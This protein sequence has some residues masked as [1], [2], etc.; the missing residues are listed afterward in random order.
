LKA[1]LNLLI[2]LQE[3]DN[4]L[5]AIEALKGDLPQRVKKL[6]MELQEAR[7]HFN[8][9][10]IDL[11]ETKKARLHWEGKVKAL[12]DKLTKYQNQLYEVKTNKEYDA[13]TLEI[14]GT[15]EKIDEGET[16]VLESIESEE[17]FDA[18]LK[19]L[20]SKIEFLEGE[21]RNRK[22]EL[23]KKIKVTE[24]ESNILEKRRQE[25]IENINRP[26]LY[27]YERI[28]KVKGTTAI[29]TVNKYACSG[30]FSAIPPQKVL[31][32]KRM[33]HLIFCES[34]GRIL[35]HKNENVTVAS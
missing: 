20:E 15:K 1:A 3:T 35:V 32:I 28:R 26:L 23:E 16:K 19:E 14:D 33:D 31:E 4:E 5:D 18:D 11:E 9:I 6:K 7:D 13:I 29:V 34:C 27:Q 12:Q 30:C 10:K 22:I 24:A 2:E 17:Q 8:K 25:L 21:L